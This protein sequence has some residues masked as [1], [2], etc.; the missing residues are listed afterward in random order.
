QGA[1]TLGVFGAG[2]GLACS[3]AGADAGPAAG[4]VASA[5][6]VAAARHADS[7][8]AW[9]CWRGADCRT[10][11]WRP[12]AGTADPAA[13]YPGVDSRQRRSAGGLARIACDRS[14]AM[15]DQPDC[16]GDYPDTLSD[17]R[18]AEEQRL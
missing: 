2:A 11:A 10:Q 12:V 15:A 6:A 17:R 14:S 7:Q 16:V 13:V 4:C 18:R 1:G 5:A 9:C 8:F 3:L